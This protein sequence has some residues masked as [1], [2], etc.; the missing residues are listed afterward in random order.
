MQN[1][2]GISHLELI[3]AVI[4]FIF[5]VTLIIFFISVDISPK[6]SEALLDA[7]EIKLREKAEIDY[8]KL[9]L[10][11]ETISSGC[12]EVPI[13][14]DLT[15]KNLS[16]KNGG[17]F[18]KFNITENNI[19]IDKGT[20]NIYEIYSFSEEIVQHE[21]ITGPCEVIT[22]NYSIS[23]Y[24]KIFIEKEI[25]QISGTDLGYEDFSITIEALDLTL[26]KENPP[27]GVE[28]QAKDLII[29]I[30]TENG[31][32]NETIINIKVW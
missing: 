4:I 20:E 5:A 2:R 6:T 10:Y 27:E 29:N 25:S 31:E 12:F 32:I 19:L 17:D 9:L 24:G 16:I 18:M 11:V 21:E 7:I 3:T 14:E 8:G 26:G 13:H 23:Y 22:Y 30:I 28:V 1:K 15:G